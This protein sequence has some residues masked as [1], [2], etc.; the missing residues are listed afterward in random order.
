ML[1]FEH[2]HKFLLAPYLEGRNLYSCRYCKN[3]ETGTQPIIGTDF[4]LVAA[5]VLS[6]SY[7][8]QYVERHHGH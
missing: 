6:A 8:V 1:W 5:L 3:G 2:L 4:L 7:L